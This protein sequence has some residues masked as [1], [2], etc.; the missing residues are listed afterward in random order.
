MNASDF[1]G[2]AAA[3]FTRIPVS[4]EVVADLDNPLSTYLKLAN[5]P[6]TFLYESVQGG[7]KWGRYSIIGLPARTTLHVHARRIVVRREGEPDEV[8]E[9]D[10]PLAWIEN[11][12]Q[13]FRLP[14]IEG[15]PRITGGLVG[16]FGYDT[17]RYIEPRLGPSSH[18]DPIGTPDILLMETD[19]LVVFDNLSG[20]LTLIVLADPAVD[21]ARE[22]ALS[23]LGELVAGLRAPLPP[24]TETHAAREIRES[25]FSEV[26]PEADFKKAVDTTRRYITE[27]ECMQ[28]ALSQRM[29]LPFTA[30]SLDLYRALRILNPSPYM[31]YLDFGDHQVVGASPE[32]LVR[33]E[34]GEVAVR[35]LAG[36][37]RR[38]ATE[39]ED[40][41]LESELLADEKE[42]AEHLM[43]IDLGR[44]DIGRIAELGSVEVSEQFSIE[45]Y[46]H[47]MH[48][49]SNV[50]GRLK[51]GMSPMDV[52]KATFPAG[53]LSGA[54]KVRALEI[55]QELEPVK[56]GVYSGAVGYLSWNGN[57]DTCIA[58][59]TAVIKDGVLNVQAGAGLVYDSDPD[60]EWQETRAKARAVFRAAAMAE[61]G[62]DRVPAA[63]E[64]DA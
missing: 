53:T 19:E 60:A 54:P 3:G 17:V 55:I 15:L 62:I 24:R 30:P 38:G 61:S 26:F 18:P 36:T 64:R 9:V 41:A 23:R 21:G 27:G 20:C 31:F 47:V 51:D 46:S 11:Y 35:P 48:I 63:L 7:E 14:D 22:Q 58:I 45:R 2:F 25:D 16:Y 44:N 34:E 8:F 42:L 40:K 57:M 6:Y 50:R 37:R 13:R 12:N 52:L 29:T 49:V 4:V 33:L 28:V 56:R 43:L 32:I 5:Q 1:A 39:A 10:D 59:R